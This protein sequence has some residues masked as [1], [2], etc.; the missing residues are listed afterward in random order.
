MSPLSRKT[1]I[2]LF[3]IL[4]LAAFLRLW[5]LPTVPPGLYPDEAANGNNAVEALHTGNFSAFYPE[6]NG[7]EALFINV[8]ALSIALFGPEPWALRLVSAFVGILT[9]AAVFFLARELFRPAPG[10]PERRWLGIPEHDLIGLAA[11][12][13]VATSFWHL[14]FSRISFRAISVPL[15]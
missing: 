7:R 9:V 8:Q 12:F 3:L 10:A 4:A 5:Q 14:N 15:L 1:V 2:G 13:F 11:A 6:N